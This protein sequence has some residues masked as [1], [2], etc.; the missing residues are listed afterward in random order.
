MMTSIG[1]AG[2]HALA[3]FAGLDHGD[4]ELVAGA[5]PNFALVSAMTSRMPLAEMTLTSAAWLMVKPDQ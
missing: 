4:G 5:G 1:F 3:D 2:Q